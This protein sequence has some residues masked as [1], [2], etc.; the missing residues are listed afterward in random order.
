MGSEREIWGVGSEGGGTKARWPEQKWVV[1]GI[2][3]SVFEVWNMD[4]SLDRI[5]GK[6]EDK[7]T[8]LGRRW[9]SNR[10]QW[11][12]SSFCHLRSPVHREHAM[13]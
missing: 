12:Y 5:L 4:P 3:D 7:V 8:G 1:D 10:W 13:Y 11:S 6:E 2:W 9:E